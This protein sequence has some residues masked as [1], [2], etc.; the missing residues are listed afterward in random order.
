MKRGTYTYNLLKV[1]KTKFNAEECRFVVVRYEGFTAL[2]L[3]KSSWV[4]SRVN[5]LNTTE[6]TWTISVSPDD[7]D[8]FGL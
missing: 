2:K 7:G 6:V 3:I 1:H 4:L 8:S 5:W